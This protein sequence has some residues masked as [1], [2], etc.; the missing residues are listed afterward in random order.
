MGIEFVR[1][2]ARL[3]PAP[4]EA[5]YIVERMKNRGIL[6]ST[7][8]KFHNVIKIKPPM[9]FSRSDADFLVESLDVVL[10]ETALSSDPL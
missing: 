8:G 1:D 2:P 9:V 5:T 6:L 10:A 7:D 4:E 3:E